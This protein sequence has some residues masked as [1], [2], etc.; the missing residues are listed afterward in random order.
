MLSTASDVLQVPPSFQASALALLIPA[1]RPDVKLLS[2]VASL[3]TGA[4]GAIIVVDDGSGPEYQSIFDELAHYP[5]VH[6]LRHAVNMGKGRALKSGMNYFLNAFPEFDGVISADADGQHIP[7][8]ILRALEVFRSSPRRMVLGARRF[9]KDVPLRS[10]IGNKLTSEVF[11][12]LTGRKLADTQTGLRAIPVALIPQ[13][14]T[15]GGERYEYEMTMLAHVCRSSTP[16]M[17]IVIR[18]VY[19]DGNRSSH[20]DPLWDSMRICF[21]LLRFYLS[22]VFAAVGFVRISAYFLTVKIFVKS[23]LSL[24]SFSIQR[25]FVFARFWEQDR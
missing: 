11:G 10:R 16:P 3:A 14:L 5:E 4:F 21:V 9:S 18:T 22:S 20:F 24:V 7:E 23:V 17:E 1:W 25:T 6:L 15:L 12:F 8:D 13:L 19:I 2:L